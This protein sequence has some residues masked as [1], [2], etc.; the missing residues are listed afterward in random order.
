M[1]RRINGSEMLIRADPRRRQH[2]T[3]GSRSEGPAAGRRH[4]LARGLPF[5]SQPPLSPRHSQ[6]F[7]ACRSYCR[8]SD[9]PRQP[10][11]PEPAGPGDR[12]PPRAAPGQIGCGNL[13]GPRNLHAKFPAETDDS[14]GSISD[15]DP[16]GRQNYG[17]S[18]A[19][20]RAGTIV[21]KACWPVDLLQITGEPAAQD[22]MAW[23][24]AICSASTARRRS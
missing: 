4:C 8:A 12:L 22:R 24:S 3:A 19:W 13:P 23:A 2:R 20:W 6:R 5:C 11:P 7:A 14:L 9:E 10:S 18:F 1:G 17:V 21:I 16:Q 15:A